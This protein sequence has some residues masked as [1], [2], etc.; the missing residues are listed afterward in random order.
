[1]YSVIPA[2]VII[3]IQVHV[4]SCKAMCFRFTVRFRITPIS[5]QRRSRSVSCAR[6]LV[7]AGNPGELFGQLVAKAHRD[8]ERY[9]PRSQSHEKVSPDDIV[10]HYGDHYGRNSY[11][12]GQNRA[13][14]I[15]PAYR[16][17]FSL[18]ASGQQKRGEPES[19]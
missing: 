6:L 14:G 16:D 9:Q 10:H 18:V 19:I 12:H 17:L 2:P 1:M 3:S 7:A 4:Q 5:A 15:N 13:Y 8:K 11:Y